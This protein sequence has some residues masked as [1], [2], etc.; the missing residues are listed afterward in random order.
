MIRQGGDQILK[1]DRCFR[2]ARFESIWYSMQV[3][4]TLSGDTTNAG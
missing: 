2:H 1:P 3:A 4:L